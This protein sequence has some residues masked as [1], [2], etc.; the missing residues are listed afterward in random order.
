MDVAV[1]LDKL[2]KY[3]ILLYFPASKKVQIYPAGLDIHLKLGGQLLY[4]N[5][6]PYRGCCIDSTDRWIKAYHYWQFKVVAQD[7]YR[8][9]EFGVTTGVSLRNNL[10]VMRDIVHSKVQRFF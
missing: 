2:G 7:Q 3:I 9:A 4:R 1:W 10:M 8:S 6:H 5:S